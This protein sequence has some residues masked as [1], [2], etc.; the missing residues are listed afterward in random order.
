MHSWP[1]ETKKRKMWASHATSS[2][3]LSPQLQ[4]DVEYQTS[5]PGAAG[6]ADESSGEGHLLFSVSRGV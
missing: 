3:S 2:V 6:Q 4:L 1:E 5:P